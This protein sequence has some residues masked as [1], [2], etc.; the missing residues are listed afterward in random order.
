MNKL[1]EELKDTVDYC[2]NEIKLITITEQEFKQFVKN[3]YEKR[4]IVPINDS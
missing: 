2:G 4:K 3:I 1:K